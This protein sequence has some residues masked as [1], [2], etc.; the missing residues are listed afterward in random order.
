MNLLETLQIG[1]RG[2]GANKLR[3]ALTVLGILIGVAAVIVLVAV[4]NGSSQA[5]TSS[6][7]QLGTNTL[8]VR[9]G[10]FGPGGDGGRTQF[11]DLTVDDAIAL[12]DDVLAPDVQ[13]ASPVVSAQAACTYEGTSYSTSITGT[14]PSYFEPSN[15][16][17]ASGTSFT[18]DDVTSSRRSVVLGQTVVDEL[19]GSV[20]PVGREIT[21]AGTPFTVVGTLEEKGSSGFQDSDDVIIAPLT[22]VQGHLTGYRSL[23][24]I[25]VQAVSG[26]AV[27]A[28]ESEV[29]SILDDRHGTTDTSSRDYQVLNQASLLSTV[30]D[31]NQVF[32]VLL[33]AVAAISLLVGGIGIT[34]I[35]LVTVTERTR[36]I[37]IRKAIGASKSAI[38]GQFLVEATVLSII[39]GV[40][41]VAV[42]LVVTQFEIAGVAP[43]IMPVSVIGAFAVSV[44]LG[45]FFGSYPAN[46]AASLRPIEALRHE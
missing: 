35:M 43:V 7:E 17:L 24:T 14:W 27:D 26:S 16:T 22:T 19:F 5:V 10:T 13:S 1:L 41:G 45:L 44:A 40:A 38:L 20:D 42:A 21:C 36:E 33:G 12:A 9:H 18:N 8:T 28:A 15:L 6:I 25:L 37:G 32:T 4:G 3:S 23:D 2:V 31:T 11:K 46:R 30:E 34:N 29:Y 39:G